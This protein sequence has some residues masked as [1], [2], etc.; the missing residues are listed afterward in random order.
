MTTRTR[1]VYTD[2]Q[3][4]EMWNRWQNGESMHDIARSFDR[5]HSSIQ[6]ILTENGGIRPRQRKR[7]PLALTLSER[8]VIS[9]GLAQQQISAGLSAIRIPQSALRYISTF[10]S[11]QGLK[12]KSLAP[13]PNQLSD[14]LQKSRPRFEISNRQTNGGV[15]RGPAPYW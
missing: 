12:P 8:E 1:I 10:V 3:K 14:L 6:R 11:R 13:T 5:Y 7:S 4:A 2:A 9:R 15:R